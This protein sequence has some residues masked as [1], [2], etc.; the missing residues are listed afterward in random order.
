MQRI[1]RTV[2]V[3]IVMLAASFSACKK[4]SSAKTELAFVNKTFTPVF[5]TKNGTTDTIA[6]GASFTVSGN[7]GDTAKATAET[8]WT[9]MGGAQKGQKIVWN[10]SELYPQS[11]SKN[12]YLNAGE[13]N[14]YLRVVNN[15][16]LQIVSVVIQTTGSSSP[17]TIP[18]P[19][20]GTYGEGYDLGYYTLVPATNM[21]VHTI[22]SYYTIYPNV[23]AGENPADTVILH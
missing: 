21:G 15:S 6:P 11:G 10:L 19:L 17:L 7:Y 8:Y 3:L 23:P 14:C 20:S 12:V 2:T 9:D 18:V 13:G 22:S 1:Y 5:F 4:S 16:H